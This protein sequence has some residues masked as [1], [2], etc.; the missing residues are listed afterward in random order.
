[1]ASMEA[2][3]VVARVLWDISESDD[4]PELGQ[5]FT[6][7]PDEVDCPVQQTVR[8]DHAFH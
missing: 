3:V 1:M 6:V 8:L 2:G 4:E 7:A 5:L